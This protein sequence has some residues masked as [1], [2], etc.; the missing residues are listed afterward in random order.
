M[1]DGATFLDTGSLDEANQLSTLLRADEHIFVEDTKD[2][3]MRDM[4]ASLPSWEGW[5]DKSK[6]R[7]SGGNSP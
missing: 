5:Q 2:G 4:M 6:S 1:P 7:N 3:G